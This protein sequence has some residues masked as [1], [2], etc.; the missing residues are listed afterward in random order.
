MAGNW[1]HSINGK[2]LRGDL[3]KGICFSDALTLFFIRDNNFFFKSVETPPLLF[4]PFVSS[5]HQ[6]WLRW[7]AWAALCSGEN[8]KGSQYGSRLWRGSRS[9]EGVGELLSR[10][11]TEEHTRNPGDPGALSHVWGPGTFT[12]IH[13][14]S[15]RPQ[16]RVQDRASDGGT[17]G[18]NQEINNLT[19]LD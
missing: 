2:M 17:G 12:R 11:E 13:T 7:A 4:L 15:W 1:L 14:S 10:W 18:V 8:E 16:W 3:G 19:L 6:C 9:R 5:V